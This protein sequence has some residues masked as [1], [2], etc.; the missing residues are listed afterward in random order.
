MARQGDLLPKP[1]R[2]RVRRA[3]VIDAGI[4]PDGKNIALFECHR[5]GWCSGWRYISSVTG[6]KLGIPC[7][8]CNRENRS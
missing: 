4:A 2:L 5:C 6:A 7:P 3:H 8:S 1:A